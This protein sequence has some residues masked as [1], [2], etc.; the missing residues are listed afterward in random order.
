VRCWR[1]QLNFLQI[2]ENMVEAGGAGMLRLV[3]NMQVVEK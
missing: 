3:E 1:E 2:K